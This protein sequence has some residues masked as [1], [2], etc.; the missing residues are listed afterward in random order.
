MPQMQVMV[1]RANYVFA[2]DQL[3]HPGFPD[4]NVHDKKLFWVKPDPAHFDEFDSKGDPRKLGAIGVDL[5]I[6]SPGVEEALLNGF[7]A[8]VQTA[9][10]AVLRRNLQRAV[11]QRYGV[12]FGWSPGYDYEVSIV[13]CPP[14]QGS[15]GGITIL[16]RTPYKG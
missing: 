16:I 5:K 15:M 10:R 7:P 8:G 14:V 4:I 12:Q 2:S 3:N 6:A 13:E 1:E 11:G 9:I